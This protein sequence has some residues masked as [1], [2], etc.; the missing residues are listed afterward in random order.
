MADFGP[1]PSDEMVEEEVA[2]WTQTHDTRQRI[3]HVLTGIRD[4]VP[5]SQIADRAR[6]SPKTARKHLEDLVDE[7]IVL[8][9]DDPQGARYQRNDEYFAWRRAHQLSIEYTEAE[10]LEQLGE[11]E[12]QEQTYQAHFDAVSPTHVDFPPADATH[13]ELHELWE[14]VTAWETLR[15]D[16]ERYRE[17]L[18]LARKRRDEPLVAD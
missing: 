3:K 17:A 16:I 6:C 10:L 9:V 4:P 2:A 15:R 1:A 5:V 11:L 18:R 8:K 7:R 13:A 12:T 14:T